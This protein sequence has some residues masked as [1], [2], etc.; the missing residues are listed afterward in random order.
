M[1]HS[2]LF[3]VDQFHKTRLYDLNDPF[4]EVNSPLKGKLSLNNDLILVN[5]SH[6]SNVRLQKTVHKLNGLLL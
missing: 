3:S 4:E 1:N 2:D 5:F 6:K